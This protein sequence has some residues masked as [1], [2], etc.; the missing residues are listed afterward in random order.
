M[1]EHKRN[2]ARTHA[3]CWRGRGRLRFDGSARRRRRAPGQ[4]RGQESEQRHRAVCT[5]EGLRGKEHP[6]PGEGGKGKIAK[7]RRQTD[8]R[9]EYVLF[10]S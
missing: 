5:D 3:Q 4:P 10:E 1:T 8:L 2:N 7:S 9:L 6:R